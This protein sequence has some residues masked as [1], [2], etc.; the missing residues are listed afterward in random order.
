MRAP[1]PDIFVR[2]LAKQN[3]KRKKN[4][5]VLIT[6]SQHYP[7]VFCLKHKNSLIIF[8]VYCMY[9]CKM[10]HKYY[11]Y[12]YLCWRPSWIIGLVK[13]QC[14]FFFLLFAW[15][16]QSMNTFFSSIFP[17]SP[18]IIF[19]VEKVHVRFISDSFR[20]LVSSAMEISATR[21]ATPCE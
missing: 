17:W 13:K 3:Q 16:F 2:V 8:C 11:V 12:F 7:A 10:I 18:N 5:T 4:K 14:Q 21:G 1:H 6:V 9:S 20:N 19:N 15:Y